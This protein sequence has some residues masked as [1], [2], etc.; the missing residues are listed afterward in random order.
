MMMLSRDQI[1]VIE[2]YVAYSESSAAAGQYTPLVA[3]KS[4]LKSRT[5]G[6]SDKQYTYRE[7]VRADINRIQETATT[8]AS[9]WVFR[10]TT[11]G[12]GLLITLV[13]LSSSCP[14]HFL[15]CI[16]PS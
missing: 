15:L 13:T 11:G 2:E 5:G 6:A 12:K 1:T 3:M 7:M 4:G 8:T 16:C 9:G 10:K 14:S